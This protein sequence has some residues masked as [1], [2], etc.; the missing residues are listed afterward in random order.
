M[1]RQ[2]LIDALNQE[3]PIYHPRNPRTP[4]MLL[5][6]TDVKID[7]R[8]VGHMAYT[9]GQRTYARTAADFTKFATTCFKTEKADD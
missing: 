9:D 7:G 5:G 3:Q 1:R 6:L 4:Y 8:W 2:E